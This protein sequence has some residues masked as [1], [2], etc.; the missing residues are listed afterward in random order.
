MKKIICTLFIVALSGCYID[1]KSID[2][3][4]RYCQDKRGVKFIRSGI[5][6]GTDR[7]LCRDGSNIT[8]GSMRKKY[9][10]K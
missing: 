6:D 8:T 7:C 4:V 9:G 1:G 10:E 2:L 3:C 5:S